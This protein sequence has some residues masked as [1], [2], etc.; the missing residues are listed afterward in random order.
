MQA[1]QFQGELQHLFFTFTIT[2][3]PTRL[4]CPRRS[5]FRSRRPNEN[6]DTHSLLLFIS[7]EQFEKD[8]LRVGLK[9]LDVPQHFLLGK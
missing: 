8:E 3:Q 1:L 2:M 5:S 6:D 4:W 9:F 7:G